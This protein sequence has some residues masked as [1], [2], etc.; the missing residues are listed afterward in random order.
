MQARTVRP[1]RLL[2]YHLMQAPDDGTPGRRSQPHAQPEGVDRHR[3]GGCCGIKI[4]QNA[5]G[6]RR[7]GVVASRGH[8][9]ADATTVGPIQGPQ[10]S[11]KRR[12]SVGL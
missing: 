2:G 5:C 12:Q 11:L 10:A 6:Q 4:M 8:A 1:S 9:R 3:V 7:K